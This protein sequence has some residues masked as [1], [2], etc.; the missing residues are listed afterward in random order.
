[1]NTTKTKKQTTA[2][3]RVVLL[4]LLMLLP[5]TV[6]AQRVLTLD[7]C[8][9]MALRNNKQIGVAKTKQEINA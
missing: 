4:G 2:M 1:M 8:R 7:S 6:G 9:A 5:M 3:A